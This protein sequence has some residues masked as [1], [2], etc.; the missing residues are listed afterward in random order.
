[1]V[2]GGPGSLRGHGSCSTAGT[3]TPGGIHNLTLALTDL[4]S[5]PYEN[6][7]RSVFKLF[8]L[9]RLDRR[10]IKTILGFLVW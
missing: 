2:S 5:R 6:L 1:M 4:A 3:T 8:K 10:L 7:L 9:G